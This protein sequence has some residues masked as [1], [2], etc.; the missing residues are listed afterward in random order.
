MPSSGRR[1][2]RSMNQAPCASIST[3]ATAPSCVCRPWSPRRDG[4]GYVVEV[5]LDADNDADLVLGSPLSGIDA[6]GLVLSNASVSEDD[7]NWSLTLTIDETGTSAVGPPIAL[8]PPD[9]VPNPFNPATTI[10][11]DLPTAGFVTVDVLDL[12]GRPLRRL[13]AADR[14]AGPGAVRW[15]GRDTAGRAVAS[16]TYFARVRRDGRAAVRAMSLVR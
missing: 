10:R 1:D 9:V 3:A 14:P 4:T 13:L 15:D 11:F 16:G 7:V 12:R 8:A 2:S 6:V 5:P